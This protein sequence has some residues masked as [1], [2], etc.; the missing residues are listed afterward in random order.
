MFSSDNI[1][2]EGLRVHNLKDLNLK[3]P[4]N[5]FVVI[6]G[7]SGSGKSSLAFD[8]LYKEGQRRYLETFSAYARQFIGNYDRPDVDFIEGLSPVI[9]IEQKTVSKNPRSTVGTVTEIYDFLRLL[10]ARVGKPYSYITGKAMT[11]F[12]EE[13]IISQII[14]DFNDKKI[15]ILAP[16]VQSRKGNYRELFEQIFR[17]GYMKARVDGEILELDHGLHVDRYKTHDIEVVVDRI[18]LSE[19][20]LKRLRTSVSE[21]LSLSKGQVFII[22]HESEDVKR[23]SKNLMCQDSG[24]SY[25]FP[26]PNNFSFNSPYGYCNTCKG[27]GKTW[28]IDINKVIVNETTSIKDGAI[29]PMGKFK[30]T[31]MFKQIRAL[32]QK[33]GASMETPYNQI[34]NEATD[35]ILNGTKGSTI[36]VYLNMGSDYGVYY[37][38]E[39]EGICTMIERHASAPQGSLKRWAKEFLCESNCSSCN[40][41]RLKKESLSFL[42]DNKNIA[43]VSKMNIHSL[44]TWINEMEKDLSKRDKAIVRDLL[45]EIK[46][47]IM[48]LDNIGLSYLDLNR[49]AKTLSGGESQRI[50]IASQIASQLTG[51][52]Y[53][54]DEPTIGL[55]PVDNQRLIGSLRKLVDMGNS[56]IVVEHDRDV[57][58][59]SDHI[60]DIGPGAGF[61]GGEVIANESTDLFI[62]KSKTI[63]AQYLRKEING[64]KLN[65][66]KGN[67]NHLHLIGASGHNLKNVSVQ[68]P[69][70]KLIC[71]CGVS[72]SGKS[73]I[74]HHTLYPILSQHFFNSKTNPLKYKTLLGLEHID[75]VIEIDQTPIG[76]TPRS[77]PSTYVGFYSDIRKLFSELP[78]A[79]MKGLK[80]GHFSFNVKGGRC[81]NCEGAGENIIEMSYL[82]DVSVTC[83]TCQGKRFDSDILSVLYKEKNIYDIL[84]MTV[85]TALEFFENQPV[86]YRKIKALE[87]VGLGY[88][89][90]G[91][92]STT[93]SGGEAQRVKLASELCKKDTGKTL[94]ILDEPTTGLHFEDVRILMEVLN[95]LVNKGNTVIIIEHNTDVIKQSDHII[96]LGPNGGDSGGEIIATGTPEEIVRNSNSKTAVY[97]KK[98]LN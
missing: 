67:G 28:D 26:E 75:K 37:D 1:T 68:I 55:H 77:N 66:R 53:I 64:F 73:S 60:L 2:I 80:S 74:I 84:N 38:L 30:D 61:H 97:L 89:S 71:I 4:R 3:I 62:E 98:E 79:K 20:K 96:E 87:S 14:N 91:Q 90:L 88:L 76:K 51:V 58:E 8:T 11:S 6:T 16:V 39:F 9:S 93:L 43:E 23:Y 31:V 17:R 25:S 72:G 70:S 35:I 13:Q 59:S 83:E 56:V 48:F 19:D 12:T 15:L 52:L 47:R 5:K 33:F 57:M 69:L 34:P 86:I 81:T 85:N 49:P 95:E 94:Y 7:V 54:L 41:Q 42:I 22:E 21:A 92:N 65:R 10:F 24:I 44:N 63:T 18:K 36:E 78:E 40:G 82:P 46:K 32:L 45:P 27:L 29:I 50:R